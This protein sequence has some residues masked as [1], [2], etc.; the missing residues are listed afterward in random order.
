MNFDNEGAAQAPENERIDIGANAPE[1][2]PSLADFFEEPSGG[3]WPKGWYGAKVIEGYATGSGKQWNTEDT[4]S[5]GGDSRNLRICFTVS[6]GKLG[7][8]NTFAS[9]NYRIEDFTAGRL[10]AVR[11]AREQFKGTQGAWTGNTDLQRSSLA[12][13][14][15]SQLENA[16]GFRMKLHPNG[17]TLPLTLVGQDIDVRFTEDEKG[18]NVINAFAKSGSKAKK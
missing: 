1:E 5:R 16:V 9:V 14:Q 15:F 2:M 13:A 11:A 12:I 17:H 7:T 4:P 18:Y 10:A 3:A 8:R 6:G